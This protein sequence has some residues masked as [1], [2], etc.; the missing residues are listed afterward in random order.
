MEKKPKGQTGNS[1]EW[2]VYVE[3]PEE[4]DRRRVIGHWEAD[5]MIGKPGST[6]LVTIT[7]RCSQHLPKSFDIA[8]SSRSDKESPAV[9]RRIGFSRDL[10]LE[11]GSQGTASPDIPRL[12]SVQP[13]ALSYQGSKLRDTSA[14]VAGQQGLEQQENHLLICG[15]HIIASGE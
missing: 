3:H 1:V 2:K 14:C 5:T 6:C 8:L 12:F 9:R 4:A 10:S 13:A 15:A 7:D 11:Q